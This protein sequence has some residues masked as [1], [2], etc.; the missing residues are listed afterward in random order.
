MRG[1]K[2]RGREEEERKEVDVKTGRKRREGGDEG[3]GEVGEARS[4]METEASAAP[5]GR[6]YSGC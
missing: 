1:E 6:L 3:E 4:P 5:E 2:I